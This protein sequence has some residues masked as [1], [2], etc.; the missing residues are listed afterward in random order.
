MTTLRTTT[1]R[2][3]TGRTTTGRQRGGFTLVELLVVITIIGILVAITVPAFSSARE[4]ARAT[5]C[6]SNLHQFYLGMATV[7]ERTGK[8][9]SG[10]FDWKRDGAVTEVGWVADLVAIGTQPGKMLCPSNES[11]MS[12][13]YVDLLT[14]DGSG[15][16]PLSN[17]AGSLPGQNPDGSAKV[18]PC[19]QILGLYPGGSPIPAGE[20][21][22]VFVETAIFGPG[23]NTNYCA[24]WWLV[25]GGAN[26]DPS[27]NL[28]SPNGHTPLNTSE[29]HCTQGPLLRSRADSSGVPSTIIPLLGDA[30]TSTEF[31]PQ[32]VGNVSDGH[33]LAYSF[34]SGPVNPTTLAAPTFAAGTPFTGPAGWWAGWNQTLQDYRQFGVP[35]NRSGHLVFA[36]GSVRSYVDESKDLFLNNGFPAGAAGFNSA[37][38]ELPPTDVFSRW[39]LK[40]E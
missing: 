27:G 19:R 16:S 8:Y 6:K 13:A 25:R 9:S 20:A 12:R 17:R 36:D 29:R 15:F 2:K 31:L 34:T 33:P 23:Y 28:Y 7:A 1:H 11:Q 24:S 35:H 30:T 21:R 32:K 22:R 26:L 37:Q 39:Q 3:T 5:T 14:S 4:A 18:N 40:A 10:A 38:V